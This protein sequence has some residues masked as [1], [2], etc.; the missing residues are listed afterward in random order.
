MVAGDSETGVVHACQARVAGNAVFEGDCATNVRSIEGIM[1]SLRPLSRD[2]MEVGITTERALP[3]HS[4]QF[5]Q[6]RFHGFPG[7]HFSITY[8]LSSRQSNGKVW[9]HIRRM[10]GGRVTPAIGK[11]IA[12]G[13]RVELTGPYGDA[14]FRSNLAGRMILIATSTGFAPIWAVAIA[15]LRERPDRMMMIITG[16]RSLDALYMAPALNELARFPNVVVVPV[17]T[18]PQSSHP[19]VRPGRPTDYLPDLIDS[20]VLYAC[21]APPMVEAIRSIAALAGATC[22]AD[23]FLPQSAPAG[24]DGL[25]TRA[26][27]WLVTAAH[28][29]SATSRKAVGWP[30]Q[31]SSRDAFGE[32]TAKVAS[33]F[34]S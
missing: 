4:G 22:H 16:G 9:F 12:P 31:G 5:A 10:K 24:Q 13:H 21:G 3:H 15:A 2:V 19:A 29:P 32:S 26:T 11:Q 20:D 27:G 1:T 23:P 14:H 33:H 8:P 30:W 18:S 34:R 6:V 25:L 17:C 7:R 28:R